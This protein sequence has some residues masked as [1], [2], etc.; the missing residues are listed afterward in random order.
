MKTTTVQLL[1][2][3]TNGTPSG[4]YDGSSTD[5]N[6]VRQAAANY[7]GGIGGLQTVAFYL[8]NFQGNI[9][10]QA[11]LDTD[12]VGDDN[13]FDVYQFDNNNVP[14][15]ENFSV[16]IDGNFTWLRARV[17]DFAAGTITKL[18]ASY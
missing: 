12:P 3:T 8:L 13:W 11:T 10:I 18:T 16:N 6:G 4:N 7:Y 15:S 5:W 2:T 17:E 14:T 1:P 9:K